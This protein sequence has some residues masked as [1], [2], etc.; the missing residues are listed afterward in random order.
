M[1]W[2]AINEIDDA[3]RRASLAEN[4]IGNTERILEYLATVTGIVDKAENW[5]A[6]DVGGLSQDQVEG[7]KEA[8]N[9]LSTK[10]SDNQSLP[11]TAK[12]W[13]RAGIL[14]FKLDRFVEAESFYRRALAVEPGYYLCLYQYL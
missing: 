10:K 14:A 7:L 2:D 1:D 13:F 4:V 6:I 8:F 5:D 12:L 9:L 3:V 11:G